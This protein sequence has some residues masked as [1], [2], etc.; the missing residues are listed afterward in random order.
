[1]QSR[2]A[3]HILAEALAMAAQIRVAVSVAVTDGA[4]HL[5]AFERQ[6]GAN[7][8]STRLAQDKAIAAALCGRPTHLLAEQAGQPPPSFDGMYGRMGFFSGGIPLVMEG[9]VIGAIGVS[10][11]QVKDNIAIAEAGVRGFVAVQSKSQTGGKPMPAPGQYDTLLRRRL[12]AED[13]FTLHLIP[14]AQISPDGDRI[15][16]V[17]T[18]FVP[19]ENKYRSHLWIVTTAGGKPQPFTEGEQQDFS[20][21]WSPDGRQIAFLSTRSGS[22]QLWIISENGGE[23][24]RLTAIKGIEAHPVWSTDGR[25]IALTVRMGKK[26][27]QSEKED[28]AGIS[29]RERFTGDVRRI[30]TLPFK[31]NRAG[32]IS[33]KFTQIVVIDVERNDKPHVLT[34]GEI[35]HYNPAWSPDGRYLAFSMRKPLVTKITDL[36]RIFV[37]DI[38]LIPAEGGVVRKLTSSMGPAYSPAFSPDG[39]TIAYIGHARQYGDYTQPSVWAVSTEG[40]G[41][42]DITGVFDRPFGNLAI[43]DLIDYNEISISPVWSPDGRFLYYLASYSGMVHLVRIHMESGLVQPLTQGKRVIHHFSISRDGQRAAFCHSDPVTPNDVMLFELNNDRE[44]RLTDVNRRL[45]TSVALAV[46]ENY[47]FPSGNTA[48]EG[49][50]LRPPATPPAKTPAVLEIHGGPMRMYGYPFFFEF[51]L[52]AANGITVVYANPRGSMGYGQEFTAAIRGDWGNKDFQDV[53]NAIETAV[54]MGGIDSVRLGVAGGSYGGFMVN[55]ILGQTDRFKAAVSM[56]SICNQYSFFGTSDFGFTRLEE[57]DAPPWRSP[58]VY[59]KYSPITFVDKV[60]TPLLM[61]HSENDLRTPMCEAEQFYTALKVLGRNVVLLRY[62]NENH[63]L[64]RSGEPWHRIHRLEA[65]VNW[66][67]EYLWPQ[68]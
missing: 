64:S 39:R 27:L 56:R 26:G 45:L 2:E 41:P 11:G 48:V 60:N 66:F 4:G 25:R 52:L 62:P 47:T 63:E 59:L 32:F 40:V 28:D 35:E 37:E 16:F 20:P 54:K 9:R 50:I 5:V 58:G 38:G 7:P 24:R 42:R 33:D 10:G 6:P 8:A 13:L 17:Q 12:K 21:A 51:Q 1:V 55:W 65:I 67:V 36:S 44:V 3:R 34:Q 46:P 30:T 18:I 23:A 43:G 49:W 15:C 22:P 31:L 14:E 57:F 29:P 61:I 68:T 53:M 19:E